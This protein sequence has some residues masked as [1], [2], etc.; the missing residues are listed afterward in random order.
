MDVQTSDGLSFTLVLRNAALALEQQMSSVHDDEFYYGPS[1]Q[2]PRPH[3]VNDDVGVLAREA[4]EEQIERSKKQESIWKI[5]S[6]DKLQLVVECVQIYSN[7]SQTSLKAGG[8]T[9]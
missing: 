9:F 6:D 8:I 5:A 3:L 7:K 4:V 2:A 1:S